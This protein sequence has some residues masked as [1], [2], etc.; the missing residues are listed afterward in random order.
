MDG[1]VT[2]AFVVKTAPELAFRIGKIETGWPAPDC[3]NV[4]M[5]VFALYDRTGTSTAPRAVEI[6][7]LIVETS[8]APV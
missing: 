4:K 2:G 7:G 8:V 5:F 3:V 6:N 1:L